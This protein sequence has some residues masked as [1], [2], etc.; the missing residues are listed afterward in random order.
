LKKASIPVRSGTSPYPEEAE[1]V[2]G[3]ATVTRFQARDVMDTQKKI[4]W[5]ISDGTGRTAVDLIKA[6]SY[7]FED[8]EIEYRVIGNVT[9]AKKIHTLIDHVRHESGM[10]VYTIVSK[11]HRRLL[12]QLCVDHHVLSVDLFGPVVSTM[13]KFLEKVPLE[14]PGLSYKFNRDYYRMVDAVDF[15]V[16]HDDGAGLDTAQA[17][18]IILIGPSRV[19]KTPLSVY[20][21]YMGWKV[22]NIPIIEG[23]EAPEFLS[24]Y[25]DKIFSL[26][27][28]P[29]LLQRRRLD[30]IRKLGDPNI[31][32]YT[33]LKV[34]NEELQYCRQ[35]AMEGQ[36]W[37]IVDMS[38]R[39]VE[40][41]A[42]EII[43]LVSI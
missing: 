14:S 41:I 18:D 9:S 13:Q 40:D 20:L 23:R 3:F 33:D 39:P 21:G 7:Q 1:W 2:Q 36:R 29:S 16:K 10:V 24:G 42:T 12:Y 22:S 8:S 6:A 15:T 34:I 25:P 4:L 35:L 43:K 19:G 5:V 17:A 26:I 31:E 32:G 38:Y 37:P 11:A 27:I 28:D 30:R